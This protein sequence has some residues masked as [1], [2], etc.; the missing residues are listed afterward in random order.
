MCKIKRTNCG[1][2]IV[3]FFVF[4]RRLILENKST[5]REAHNTHLHLHTNTKDKTRTWMNFAE[6]HSVFDLRLKCLLVS[7]WFTIFILFC[8]T[9]ASVSFLTFPELWIA[10]V[11]FLFFYMRV[12]KSILSIAIETSRHTATFLTVGNLCMYSLEIINY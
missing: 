2:L 3:V 11:R 1:I 9:V 10:S 7:N 4:I 12:D 8:F 5:E 6:K